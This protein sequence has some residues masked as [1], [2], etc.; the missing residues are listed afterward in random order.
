MVG[1]LA[2]LTVFLSQ[3]PIHLSTPLHRHGQAWARTPAARRRARVRRAAGYG[4]GGAPN[5]AAIAGAL[6]WYS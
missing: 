6:W 3:S 1:R 4:V 2:C 5:Q